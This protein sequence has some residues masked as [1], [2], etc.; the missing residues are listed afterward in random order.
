MPEGGLTARPALS[1]VGSGDAGGDNASEAV[2]EL[3]AI[4][5]NNL[6]RLRTRQGHSLERLAKLS[7]VSRAMLGQIENGKS[8]PTISTLWRIATALGVPFAQLLAAEKVQR[9]AV[10]RARDAKVLAS[11]GGH[12][13]SRALFPFEDERHVEF[14]ELRLA[15]HH[16]EDAPAHQAGTRE[17]LLIGHGVVEIT[18]GGDPPC[19]LE[20]G[21]AILFEA[22]LPHAYRNISD[23]EAVIYLVMTYA[24]RVG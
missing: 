24:T 17:N 20:A 23:T 3:P 13:T 14:Y 15:P 1:P 12:F 10:L 5:G 2:A 22:D 21:D 8:V 4:L 16:R 7:G 19:V 6:R 11:S 18:V 9:M